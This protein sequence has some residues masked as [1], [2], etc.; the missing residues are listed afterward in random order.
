MTV[1]TLKE[2][3]NG[4]LVLKDKIKDIIDDEYPDSYLIP[5]SKEDQSIVHKLLEY[6]KFGEQSF[7][8][9]KPSEDSVSACK[10]FGQC[11]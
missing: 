4:E 6:M 9:I 10:L 7:F 3:E 1:C 2:N 5:K 11:S 8:F